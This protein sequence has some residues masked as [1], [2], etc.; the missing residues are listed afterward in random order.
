M[1]NN[2]KTIAL[3]VMSL[4]VFASCSH[5]QAK[6]TPAPKVEVKTIKPECLLGDSIKKL[7]A[8]NTVIYNTQGGT[9]YTLTKSTLGDIEFQ[10]VEINPCQEDDECIKNMC[11]GSMI[12]NKS[13]NK[14]YNKALLF[15]KNQYG[16]PTIEKQGVSADKVAKYTRAIWKFKNMAIS[17]FATVPLYEER[18][19]LLVTFATYQ[20]IDK[21]QMFF[22]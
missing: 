9:K 18:G 8:N 1:I 19:T 21:L 5:K 22:Q 3:T 14:E 16:N 11:Y 4:A 15:L 10:H 17:L 2:I 13:M 20:D 12:S 6:E 7:I